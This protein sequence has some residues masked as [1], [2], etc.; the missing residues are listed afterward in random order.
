MARSRKWRNPGMNCIE[1]INKNPDILLPCLL[2]LLLLLILLSSFFLLSLIPA[3]GGGA[4]LS[5][6]LLSPSFL[7]PNLSFSMSLLK[8][9]T[10]TL[11]L[12]P[13]WGFGMAPVT[14]GGA[15]ARQP[16]KKHVLFSFH[17]TSYHQPFSLHIKNL[18]ISLKTTSGKK[19]DIFSSLCFHKLFLL[20]WIVRG[21]MD[22][23]LQMV[24][25][26]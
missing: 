6:F 16:E 20:V 18:Y 24:D 1:K 11:C 19:N 17:C 22:R 23:I 13:A 3:P 15:D 14:F 5:P 10:C 4:S 21:K 26:R 7:S 9:D 12:R 25:N 2:D 8:L